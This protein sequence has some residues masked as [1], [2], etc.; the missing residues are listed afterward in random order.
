MFLFL[1]TKLQFAAKILQAS[2]ISQKHHSNFQY[3]L[4]K[5]KAKLWTPP[6]GKYKLA[7]YDDEF[8]GRYLW[9]RSPNCLIGLI[10][11]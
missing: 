8:T 7:H 2:K 3:T 6:P 5:G 1:F 4:T 11:N 10:I 9:K